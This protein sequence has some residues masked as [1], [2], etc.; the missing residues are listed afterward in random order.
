[1]RL[2]ASME[3]IITI[4]RIWRTSLYISVTL[5]KYVS[6]FVEALE[7]CYIIDKEFSG[8]WNIYNYNDWPTIYH[9]LDPFETCMRQRDAKYVYLI[10]A[11]G[12]PLLSNC[13]TEKGVCFNKGRFNH[14][15]YVY[16]YSGECYALTIHIMSKQH[17]CIHLY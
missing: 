12:A 15:R 4:A 16:T 14:F 6:V 13:F 8:A 9:Q 11:T 1:M 3:D 10:P 5:F 7:D 2:N 17:Q